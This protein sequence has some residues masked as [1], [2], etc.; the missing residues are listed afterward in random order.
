VSLALVLDAVALS[1]FARQRGQRFREARAALEAARRLQRD[2]VVPAVI[3]AELYR[4]HGHNQVIDAC[5]SRESWIR[6]PEADHGRPGSPS[7]TSGRSARDGARRRA[8]REAGRPAALSRSDVHRAIMSCR[9]GII[10][11]AG[12]RSAETL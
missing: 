3:L 11:N 6:A 7:S 1:G 2:V 5:L 10:T 9:F 4:G 8:K 12:R